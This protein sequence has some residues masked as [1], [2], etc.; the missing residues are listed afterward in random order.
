[1][2]A[3]RS[4]V[5][6]L[7]DLQS[8]AMPTIAQKYGLTPREADV[9]EGLFNGRTAPYIARDLSVS[10]NTV[11]SHAKHIYAKLSVHSQQELIDLIMSLVSTEKNSG[12]VYQHK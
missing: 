8:N 6:P 5:T 2:S 3:K 1:M 12:Q 11:R 9:L 4:R 10:I 7:N